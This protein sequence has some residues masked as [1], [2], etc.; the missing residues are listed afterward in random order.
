MILVPVS[1]DAGTALV[2]VVVTTATATATA[3]GPAVAPTG[4]AF[5]TAATTSNVIFVVLQSTTS[6][7][8]FQWK[9]LLCNIL[10]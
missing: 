10:K 3:T 5:A 1:T 2:V 6:N 9:L 8:C 7:Q 4:I